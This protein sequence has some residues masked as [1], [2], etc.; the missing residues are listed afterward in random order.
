LAIAVI[1]RHELSGK[2]EHA[3]Q[4]YQANDPQSR[5]QIWSRYL[6]QTQKNNSET[7]EIQA[8]D[9]LGRPSFKRFTDKFQR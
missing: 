7:G 1:V 3:G 4:Y 5:V 2:N 6:Q 9:F 8:A